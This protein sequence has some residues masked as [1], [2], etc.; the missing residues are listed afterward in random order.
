MDSDIHAMQKKM[1]NKPISFLFVN[2]GGGNR[3]IFKRVLV[4]KKRGK[5]H[6]RKLQKHKNKTWLPRKKPNLGRGHTKMNI[7][8][9]F[10]RF[11]FFWVVEEEEKKKVKAMV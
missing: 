4:W 5:L 10:L 7:Q 8:K 1:R 2:S 3:S 6:G 11:V 9:N